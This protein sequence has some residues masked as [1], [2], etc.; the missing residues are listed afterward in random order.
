MQKPVS[1]DRFVEA[2]KRLRDY[3]FEMVLLPNGDGI[4]GAD[5]E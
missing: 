1:F 5:R 2:L 4:S 3:W